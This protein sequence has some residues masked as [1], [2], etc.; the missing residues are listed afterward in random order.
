MEMN[1]DNFSVSEVEEIKSYTKIGEQLKRMGM[2]IQA[3]KSA[4]STVEEINAKIFDIEFALGMSIKQFLDSS[5]D[6]KNFKVEDQVDYVRKELKSEQKL[7]NE[8]A[9]RGSLNIPLIISQLVSVKSQLKTIDNYNDFVKKQFRILNL[10]YNGD[11]GLLAYE[12]NI[13]GVR[14]NRNKEDLKKYYKEM[15][16]AFIGSFIDTMT[17]VEMNGVEYDLSKINAEDNGRLAF[18]NDFVSYY[19][20]LRESHTYVRNPFFQNLRIKT[21]KGYKTIYIEELKAQDSNV[22]DLLKTGFRLLSETDKQLFRTYNLL[23]NGFSSFQGSMNLVIDNK[24]ESD[25]TS[26]LKSKKFTEAEA[27]KIFTDVAQVSNL[28]L[29]KN[30]NVFKYDNDDYKTL[31]VTPDLEKTTNK[32][33]ILLDRVKQGK[34]SFPVIY[35]KN[36]EGKFEVSTMEYGTPFNIYSTISR[37][38]FPGKSY[39]ELSFQDIAEMKQN[40]SLE[41]VGSENKFSG[42]SPKSSVKTLAMPVSGDSVILRDGTKATVKRDSEDVDHIATIKAIES[43]PSKVDSRLAFERATSKK[44]EFLVDKIRKSY[45]NVKIEFI[46]SL[47]AP[48]GMIRNGIIYL[49]ESRIQY[50]TPMHEISHIHL[51][52]IKEASHSVY[53]NLKAEAERMLLS[54]DKIALAVRSKYSDLNGEDLMDEIIVTVMGLSTVDKVKELLASQNINPSESDS[55]FKKIF[56]FIR[57]ILNAFSNSISSLFGSPKIAIDQDMTI[58]DF[59]N[60]LFDAIANESVVSTISSEELSYLLPSEA[61]SRPLTK[62]STLNDLDTSLA[63]NNLSQDDNEEILIS[64][65][66]QIMSNNEGILPDSYIGKEV[67]FKGDVFSDE[68]TNILK[69]VIKEQKEYN[70]KQ[71]DNLISFVTK[72]G[73]KREHVGLAFGYNTDFKGDKVTKYDQDFVMKIANAIKYDGHASIMR[74]SQLKDNKKYGHLYNPDFEFDD[75]IVVI[76]DIEGK[77]VLQ[78]YS[79]YNKLISSFDHY[80]KDLNILDNF[81]NKQTSYKARLNMRNTQRART[82]INMMLMRNYFNSIDVQVSDMG[83]LELTANKSRVDIIDQVKH[84]SNLKKMSTIPEFMERLSPSV[85]AMFEDSVNATAHIDYYKVLMSFYESRGSY[86]VSHKYLK[87]IV[88][89]HKGGTTSLATMAEIL[90]YRLTFLQSENKTHDPENYNPYNLHEV[91][92][93]IKALADIEYLGH[94]G[95]PKNERREMSV[96]R[97]WGGTIDTIGDENVQHIRRVLLR[98]NSLIVDNYVEKMKKFRGTKKSDGMFKW[99]EKRYGKIS[100]SY[101]IDN[102]DN[103][104]EDLYVILEGENGERINTGH[105]YWTTDQELDPLYAKEAQKRLNEDPSFKEVLDKGKEIVDH[106]EDI[107]IGHIIAFRRKTKMRS[108]DASGQDVFY[109]EKEAREDLKRMSYRKGMIP[110]MNKR[111]SAY[112]SAGR[113]GKG[114]MKLGSE[115]SN[116]SDI[117]DDIPFEAIKEEEE[118]NAIRDVFISQMGIFDYSKD[119]HG[120]IN[121]IERELGFTFKDN[122]PVL[123][124]AEKNSGMMKDLE[125]IM[126]Y[127]TMSVIRKDLYEK[128]VMPIVNGVRT[129][130]L[131]DMV[132]RDINNKELLD[133]IDRYTKQ[134]IHNRRLR[135]KSPF[136]GL[137]VD[138]SASLL[139]KAGSTM[140]MSL[141]FNIGILSATTNAAYAFV[142]GI[143]NNISEMFGVEVFGPKANQLLAASGEF[144][145]KYNLVSQLAF[146]YK[147][148]STEDY[149]MIQHRMHQ[150]TKRTIFSTFYVN[151]LNWATDLYARSTAMVAMMKN[152]GTFDAHYYDQET[153]EV[154]Y[155]VLKDNRIYEDGVLTDKGRQFAKDLRERLIADG[156]QDD[157]IAVVED[158]QY[159]PT[160]AYDRFEGTKFKAYANRYIVGNYDNK[161]KPVFGN[162]IVGR[163]FGMFK[164]FMTNRINN[165][166]IRGQYVDGLGQYVTR[167]EISDVDGKPAYVTKWEAEFVEGYLKTITRTLNEAIKARDIRYWHNLND[168]EKRNVI[169]GGVNLSAWLFMLIVYSML[170]GDD[171]DEAEKEGKIPPY[172]ILKNFKYSYQS[173]L[174]VPLLFEAAKNPFAIVDI[175]TGLFTDIYGNFDLSRYPGKTQFNSISEAI[176]L[177]SGED[178]HALRRQKIEEKRRERKREQIIQKHLDGLNN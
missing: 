60:Q 84:T 145:T 1:T 114:L 81:V 9:I 22:I 104:F 178:M 25:Y 164:N 20:S 36:E 93:L 115:L 103:V 7:S 97:K 130:L 79:Y 46:N 5:S 45:P 135:M 90:K 75:F 118:M 6:P 69:N 24:I 4:G 122:K 136:L 76:R 111:S 106:I 120:N 72:Y 15:D 129:M 160:R 73:S 66:R 52:L 65:L 167:L 151:W 87:S 161:S 68:A 98:T 56:N 155:D 154:G 70:N 132:N 112:F 101:I 41:V 17:S 12:K 92:F 108:K 86:D 54:N 109:G 91:E 102:S 150:K 113:V 175:S 74:Y 99:F 82:T 105:I 94:D 71:K 121:R 30:H 124:D 89:L 163:L 78:F 34:L 162:V 170:V 142:E 157:S 19:N 64:R 153:G 126:N 131:D 38:D 177:I 159:M 42:I 137:D 50:D 43:K 140:V 40:G 100:Q 156:L 61:Q 37:S 110:L 134:A 83:I 127:F 85:Q 47:T 3:Y 152:E 18:V 123:L 171:W 29:S 21:L 125:T 117:Y 172:R 10:E 23:L 58:E 133:F 143:T 95:I 173:L 59:A 31:S 32:E 44:L 55:I 2:V 144:F 141:N 16:R 146:D 57:K 11:K 62:I 14:G 51:A 169:K 13:T 28:G 88:D 147:T 138:K 77:P 39:M 176:N 35:R 96:A 107:L 80:S 27:K 119:P 168:S 149:E 139:M 148:F 116:I 174:A 166:F 158:G 53:S 128:N 165:A 26:Y 63:R 49:N 33:I 48:I 8:T 67:V